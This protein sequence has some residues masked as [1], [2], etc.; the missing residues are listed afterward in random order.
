MTSLVRRFPF[1]ASLLAAPPA[2]R[3]TAVSIVT[4]AATPPPLFAPGPDP[5]LEELR[6]AAMR[7]MFPK[8]YSWC[9]SRWEWSIAME[10]HAYL[11]AAT[12][13]GDLEQR[14]RTVERR[15]HFNG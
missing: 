7:K 5:E 11:A 9:A 14:I 3:R 6:G 2:E 12:S 1:L 4:H 13:V 10:V 8:L 15:R